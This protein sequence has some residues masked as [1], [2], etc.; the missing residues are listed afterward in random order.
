MRASRNEWVYA[1]FTH[2]RIFIM[3]GLC[4]ERS[5]LKRTCVRTRTLA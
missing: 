2:V 5:E 1:F 4:A 3:R